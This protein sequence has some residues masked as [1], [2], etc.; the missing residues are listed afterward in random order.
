MK[1]I[2]VFV[3]T[4]YK[5]LELIHTPYDGLL[6]VLIKGENTT[7]CPGG[8]PRTVQLSFSC[9][10]RHGL[11]RPIKKMSSLCSAQFAWPTIAA[12]NQAV[13]KDV[14]PI[15]KN[16][17]SKCYTY[18]SSGEVRDLSPLIVDD[19]YEVLSMP[20]VNSTRSPKK[21]FINVCSEVGKSCRNGQS[22]TAACSRARGPVSTRDIVEH[23]GLVRRSS[24]H[25]D[26]VSDEVVLTYQ[27][28]S[29][30]S[31]D[32]YKCTHQTHIR[33]KCPKRSHDVNMYGLE[34]RKPFL[35]STSDCETVIEWETDH[36][37]P[38]HK[39]RGNMS[40]C[41]IE[42][43]VD[44]F[45]IDLSP[46]QKM[47]QIVVKNITVNGQSFD[48]VLSV[49]GSFPSDGKTCPK[50]DWKSNSVCINSSQS[51]HLI[52]SRGIQPTEP[53]LAYN[54]GSITLVYPTN[55][56][57]NDLCT[58]R[59]A[60]P[61]TTLNFICDT[62]TE[63]NATLASLTPTC[64]FGFDVRSKHACHPSHLAV[65][66]CAI[67]YNGT[68]FD[69]SPLRKKA[70][71]YL[72]MASVNPNRVNSAY[73]LSPH[74][75]IL[76][77]VCGAIPKVIR[78]NGTCVNAPQDSAACL[79]NGK[80][81]ESRNIGQFING[82]IYDP[83]M[84]VINITYETTD[85]KTKKAISTISFKCAPGILD[86]SPILVTRTE[87]TSHDFFGFEW[88]TS[89][90]CPLKT[91]F[92]TD[93]IVTDDSL[94]YTFDLTPLRQ[95]HPY[96]VDWNTPK[97]NYTFHLSVCGNLK[98]NPCEKKDQNAGI[99][100]VDKKSGDF[101]VSGQGNG[102]LT[103]YDG[104][105]KLTYINGS[106]YRNADKT[107]R[108]AEIAFICDEEA[109]ARNGG[110][111]ALEHVAEGNFTYSFRWYTK[112]ACPDFENI[113]PCL[114]TNGTYSIDLS[115][116]SL[117]TS[118]HFEVAGIKRSAGAAHDKYFANVCRPV[119]PLRDLPNCRRGSALCWHSVD[120]NGNAVVTSLGIPTSPPN[121]NDG[122]NLSIVYQN[123]D[124][125]YNEHDKVNTTWSS[126]IN[127]VCDE[128]EGVD[129][130]FK[131]TEDGPCF[132]K[133]EWKTGLVCGVSTEAPVTDIPYRG[134][135][136]LTP[137]KSDGTRTKSS[138]PGAAGIIVITVISFIVVLFA[139]FI[140][141]NREAR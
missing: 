39:L 86:S 85:V 116:M 21:Y 9:D 71:E 36:A 90:A 65:P 30:T 83:D 89:A 100:Q 79:Y 91:S 82:P 75:R 70:H 94:G 25:F 109:D 22:G 107:P 16:I 37:C 135:T 96:L 131:K 126:W 1:L 47:G 84:K 119:N 6:F 10:R 108:N 40:T 51:S 48:A 62:N 104:V 33:F 42:G 93:C 66:S 68:M 55:T 99:C 52:G 67:E 34:S 17:L 2:A 26:E 113:V 32:S 63:F 123:G 31:S 130:S 46:L 76:I 112:Y 41:L 53:E 23:L 59:K 44:D 8:T 132:K 122:V 5:D 74:E 81:K 61:V 3:E 106:K 124:P 43:D 60:S 14:H 125:C 77:N 54:D 92:G 80:T 24:L 15:S 38:I 49:C 140:I 118:N 134:P 141:V 105:L 102:N 121:F 101:Y 137:S 138:K 20:E 35:L 27:D 111:P 103:Y 45:K 4:G 50:N 7:L 128:S 73:S 87:N 78:N 58:D 18:D 13:S 110:K 12:C 88:K 95:E 133:F 98:Y 114:W 28:I 64:E 127:F 97:G 136:E 139:I 56:N 72:W 69:L 120:S 57:Q 117:V 129:G 29:S 11:G 115:P 19:G